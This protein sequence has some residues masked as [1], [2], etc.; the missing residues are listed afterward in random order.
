MPFINAICQQYVNANMQYA[1]MQY[2]NVNMQYVDMQYANLQYVNIQ[3]AMTKHSFTNI[4]SML[5]RK[6]S[7]YS[8]NNMYSHRRRNINLSGGGGTPTPFIIY[9]N[10]FDLIKKNCTKP[11]QI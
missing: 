7:M 5:A 3:H 6:M 11:L 9:N 2:V 1:G 4:C 8:P 10:C